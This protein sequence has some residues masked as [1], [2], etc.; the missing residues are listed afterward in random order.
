[1]LPME[2]QIGD[3]F[4]D[5]DFE[6]EVVTHPAA[7]HGGKSLRARSAAVL[8]HLHAPRFVDLAPREVYPTLL[9]EGT[10]LCSERTMYRLLAQH[11]SSHEP[12]RVHHPHGVASIAGSPAA[13]T[14]QARPGG[15]KRRSRSLCVGN[16]E[17]GE[18]RRQH[19]TFCPKRRP[20]RHRSRVFDFESPDAHCCQA[21]LRRSR[22]FGR[23]Q[24]PDCLFPGLPFSSSAL[25]CHAPKATDRLGLALNV[26]EKGRV[27][28]SLEPILDEGPEDEHAD[29]GEP[30][31]NTPGGA[32]VRQHMEDRT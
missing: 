24:I 3:R 31:A 1:M 11:E 26:G 12:E 4:T 9:D 27:V 19:A 15:G 23:C 2:I 20:S 32:S 25:T 21:I 5:H 22:P 29:V 17:V 7:L 13:S 30:G 6:W 14:R 8:A 18:R 16:R 28:I 10:Y